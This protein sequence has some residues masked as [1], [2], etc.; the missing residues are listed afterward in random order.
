MPK[1]KDIEP[2]STTTFKIRMSIKT[3]LEALRAKEASSYWSTRPELSFMGY[4]LELGLTKYRVA[5]LP[6]EMEYNATRDTSEPEPEY[7][8]PPPDGAKRKKKAV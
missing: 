1:R 8:V 7:E 4:L 2:P 3:H 6:T 5:I